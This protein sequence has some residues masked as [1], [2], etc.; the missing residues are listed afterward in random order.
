MRKIININRK[1]AFAKETE[2]PSAI[3]E[4]WN[5]VNLPHSWNAIDGQDGGNDYYR[6]TC[7]YVRELDREEIPEADRYYLE[8]RGANS[9]ADVY[10]NGKRQA[11]TRAVMLH[12]NLML[13]NI[14]AKAKT[15]LSLTLLTT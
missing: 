1:W 5:F 11:I 8:I 7:C 4:K 10:V 6:G 13:P 2:I 12:L 15:P 3:P 9:S 14:S